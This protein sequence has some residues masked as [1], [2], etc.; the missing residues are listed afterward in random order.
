M[1]FAVSISF[2]VFGLFGAFAQISNVT[3]EFPLPASLS[4]S[5]GIIYFNGKLITHNDSGGNNE[6]YEVDL[7]TKVVIRTVTI[8]N[9]QNVDWEWIVTD[10]FSD[11]PE[12]DKTL[13]DV[14]SYANGIY[15]VN[16]TS[17]NG[18]V[19]TKKLI[20]N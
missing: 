13:I 1:K 9:A 4:E 12:T 15:I 16:V 17:E 7:G 8:S 19:Y 5:S 6:L 14:S 3:E 20:K 2:F 10:D 11:N 18:Q